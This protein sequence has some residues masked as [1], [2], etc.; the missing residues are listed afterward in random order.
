[1]HAAE[2]GRGILLR[3]Q[4]F[5]LK[6]LDINITHNVPGCFLNGEIVPTGTRRRL[7]VDNPTIP[8]WH[9]RERRWRKS[10]KYGTYAW[11]Q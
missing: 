3:S 4:D 9:H 1:M 10:E 7:E 5:R 11:A 2:M 8:K 6:Y